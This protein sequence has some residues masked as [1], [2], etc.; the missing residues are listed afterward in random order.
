MRGLGLKQARIRNKNRVNVLSWITH[1][2]ELQYGRYAT[3]NDIHRLSGMNKESIR[4]HIKVL[5]DESII[6]EEDIGYNS[7]GFMTLD[8]FNTIKHNKENTRK[9]LSNTKQH[10]YELKYPK[11]QEPI[12]KREKLTG[13]DY[14]SLTGKQ[15]RKKENMRLK[16]LRDSKI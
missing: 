14:G 15:E 12:P 1:T 3:I 6:L 10:I 8:F 16:E 11:F 7:K 13:R 9:M 5:L 2:N 4:N